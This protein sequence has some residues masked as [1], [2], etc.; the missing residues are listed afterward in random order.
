MRIDYTVICSEKKLHKCTEVLLKDGEEDT[1]KEIGEKDV[2]CVNGRGKTNC[3]AVHVG[4][5]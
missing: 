4:M 2:Q 5:L 1:R 3:W